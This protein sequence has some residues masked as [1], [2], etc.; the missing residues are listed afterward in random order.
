MTVYENEC[1][2]CA[3]G[4]FPCLGDSCPNR[5]VPHY[6][7]DGCGVEDTL[8]RYNGEVLCMDC[9][10][11]TSTEYGECGGC[12]EIGALIEVDEEVMCKYCAMS[13]LEE[14]DGEF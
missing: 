6:L 2:D 14:Y 12:G 10:E 7:C 1:C 9:I 13:E 8:Y 3:T 4:A 11:S 5:R